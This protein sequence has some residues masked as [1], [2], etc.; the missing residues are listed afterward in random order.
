[1][2]AVQRSAMIMYCTE[3][4]PDQVWREIVLIHWVIKSAIIDGKKG[5]LKQSGVGEN[6]QKTY[7]NLD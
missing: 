4:G 1:M 2:W 7:I 3:M 6:K 5:Q